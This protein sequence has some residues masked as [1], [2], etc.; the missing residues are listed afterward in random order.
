M[1]AVGKII[2]KNA[3]PPDYFVSYTGEDTDWAVCIAWW[4]EGAGFS[5]I[6]QEWDFR[7]GHNFISMMQLGM[8]ARHVIA[9]L[10]PAYL[11][12]H[13]CQQECA[14]AL[15]EDPT[16]AYRKLIPVRVKHCNPEG[17][18]G[19]VIYIDL[20]AQEK[21]K[22]RKIFLDGLPPRTKPLIEPPFPGDATPEYDFNT[23]S[24]RKSYD[25]G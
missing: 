21:D 18:L 13:R 23:L 8:R 2:S 5:A 4:L 14:A 20:Y 9:I 17:L 6:V 16:G 11:E 15:A 22:A 3:P 7:P 25:E 10:S 19:P 1:P 12:A 24:G